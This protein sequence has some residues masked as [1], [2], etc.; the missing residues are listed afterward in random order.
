[1]VLTKKQVSTGGRRLVKAEQSY[2]ENTDKE[3]ESD[4]GIRTR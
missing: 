1:M 3:V 2:T 4:E